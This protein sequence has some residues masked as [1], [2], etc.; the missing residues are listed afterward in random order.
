MERYY[1]PDIET[2]PREQITAWQNEKLVKQV[3]HVWDHVPYYRKL[4][5]E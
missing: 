4:M 3:R 1:Q 2:A 5:E